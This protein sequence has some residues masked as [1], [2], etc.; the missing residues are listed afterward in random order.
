MG[1]KRILAAVLMLVLL[2]GMTAYLPVKAEEKLT[3]LKLIESLIREIEASG[4]R[5]DIGIKN[6]ISIVSGKKTIKVNGK[7][8]KSGTITK[9]ASKYKLT[10]EEASVCA[11][12]IKL[13]LMSSS[14]IKKY[15]KTVT[16]GDASV[17]ISKAEEM[18]YGKIKEA[19]I[20]FVIENRIADIGKVKTAAGKNALAKAYI[21]GYLE[22]KAQKKYSHLRLLEP[23]KKLD[24]KSAALI[25]G[26]LF[27]REK[28]VLLSEDYQVIRTKNLPRNAEYYPYIL[29]SYG[30]EYY[31]TGFNGITKSFFEKGKGI[32]AD[33]LS[34]R[35]KRTNFA[36]VYP[37]EIGEFNV[38]KYPGDDFPYRSNIFLDCYRNDE[39]PKL[40]ALSS[41][42]FYTYALNVDYRTVKNDKKW[43]EVMKKYL[44]EE[45]LEDYI[46]HCIENRTIIECDTVS[47][48]V[49]GVYWYAGDYNCKVYAHMR[50]I[51]D[52]P[53]EEGFT[54]G[55]DQDT[56][57]Y[58]YPVRRGYESGTLFTRS[59]LGKLYMDYKMG[60]W[61]DF[62]FN[63]NGLSDSYGCLNCSNTSRGIMI[64]YTGLM[65]WLY[66]LPF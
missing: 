25:V 47:A 62:F 10:K 41:E 34:E 38:L 48:D 54:S 6:N 35:M 65:P 56:Y 21:S 50:V 28:R 39:T 4:S 31:D 9:Y 58:L 20:K 3:G 26:R 57:G 14:D 44:S 13:K 45:E 17:I 2:A 27:N 24:A 66:K 1:K 16:V 33:S 40:L 5:T 12:A 23:K 63:T 61:T 52:R 49:S 64:D 53:L 22:G 42:E 19:D 8:I 60:E 36:F 32:G 55:D 30:N 59:V 43:Q 51:S 18:L 11:V 15:K 29:D 46:A 37:C 7:K